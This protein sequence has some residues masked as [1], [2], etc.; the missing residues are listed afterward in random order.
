MAFSEFVDKSVLLQE[1]VCLAILGVSENETSLVEHGDLVVL[2]EL[3]P[4]VP[5]N[6]RI[7]DKCSIAR[8]ILQDSN[9]VI[10]L[11]LGEN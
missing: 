4:L 8:E 5:P 9:R 11:V 6:K 1:G 2:L 3:S 10:T 7:V